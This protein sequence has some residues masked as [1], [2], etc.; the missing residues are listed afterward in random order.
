[1]QYEVEDKGRFKM[2]HIIGNI[3]PE[4][5]TKVLD[6]TISRYIESGCHDFV[7][8]LERTT[9]LD[10]SGIGIFIHC[11][12]DVQEN[13]GSIYIIAEESQVKEVLRMVGIDRLIKIYNSEE[14][15]VG[16]HKDAAS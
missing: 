8:N 11:L 12:C 15:F 1:M 13:N 5:S 7:F 10:S 4:V 14:A 3:T 16:E 9:Y 6:E 2:I